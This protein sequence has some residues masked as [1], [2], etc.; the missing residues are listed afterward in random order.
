MK[1]TVGTA[2]LMDHFAISRSTACRWGEEGR[3]SA[4]K[5]EDQWVFDYQEALNRWLVVVCG[6]QPSEEP[7]RDMNDLLG[8][9][10]DLALG[11][12]ICFEEAAQLKILE[13]ARA[14]LA[15]E[16][17]FAWSVVQGVREGLRGNSLFSFLEIGLQLVPIH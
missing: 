4:R 7:I 13:L 16:S 14:L 6:Q 12:E 3:F 9:V 11:D 2:W 15:T 1:K 10:W 17:R 5:V 8:L